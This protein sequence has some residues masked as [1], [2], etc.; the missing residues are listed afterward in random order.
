ML[1]QEAPERLQDSIE[2]IDWSSHCL[3]DAINP[4]LNLS[5]LET[6]VVEPAPEPIDVIGKVLGT[7]EIFRPQAEEQDVT[8]RTYGPDEAITSRSRTQ[9][10]V[11]RT[12]SP[13]LVRV[14]LSG[15]RGHRASGQRTGAP[16]Y[17]TA[18]GTHKWNHRGGQREGRGY[19]LYRPLS[20]GRGSG[21]EKSWGDERPEGES[22]PG[23][24]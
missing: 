11:A 4:V 23:S 12:T 1:A 18:D 9:A 10:L 14:V 8:L 6:G 13:P 5:K 3:L 16:H 19:H 7:A 17:G 21:G 24:D 20:A 22:R 2:H 15:R